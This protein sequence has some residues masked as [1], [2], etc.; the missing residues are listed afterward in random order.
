MQK[1]VME[2]RLC[3][4]IFTK[5]RQKREKKWRYYE[6]HEFHKQN[7]TIFHGNNAY[8]H[9]AMAF[10]K[11]ESAADLIDKFH[12]LEKTRIEKGLLRRLFG[13]S[14]V[15]YEVSAPNP[16]PTEQPEKED[17]PVL[18]SELKKP[19]FPFLDVD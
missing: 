18:D 10:S 12:N 19:S 1:R 15:D 2:F 11:Y 4:R 9:N 14:K 6:V 5:K 7:N 16:V 8:N 3:I 13:T 17:K